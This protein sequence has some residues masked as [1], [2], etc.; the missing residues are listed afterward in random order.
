[1]DQSGHP[2][3]APPHERAE[4]PAASRRKGARRVSGVSGDCGGT[5]TTVIRGHPSVLAHERIFGSSRTMHTNMVASGIDSGEL[6]LIAIP[7]Y[8][9]DRAPHGVEV[10][11][12]G[13]EVL[14]PEEELTYTRWTALFRLVDTDRELSAPEAGDV[15]AL[16]PHGIASE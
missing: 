13:I 14:S 5:S 16:L 7:G 9:P 12:H 10:G 3:N 8:S 1:M 15:T 6:A 2:D 11:L 4:M